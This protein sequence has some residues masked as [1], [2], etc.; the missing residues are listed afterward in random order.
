MIVEDQYLGKGYSIP[1]K[2][3]KEKCHSRAGYS[4]R[5]SGLV[6]EYSLLKS[7]DCACDSK[8]LVRCAGADLVKIM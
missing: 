7:Y 4:H 2:D 5:Y 3:G 1:E 6:L 8:E